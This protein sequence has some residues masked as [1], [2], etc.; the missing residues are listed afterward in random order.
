[1]SIDHQSRWR[2]GVVMA[3]MLALACGGSSPST[4]VDGGSSASTTVCMG[5]ANLAQDLGCAGIQGCV[6]PGAECS[7][8]AKAWVACVQTDLSQCHCESGDDSLNC[9]GAYKPDEGPA[10]CVAQVAAYKAC[11]GMD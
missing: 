11:A 10:K 3:A 8:E 9:E 6:E 2:G 4:P 7:D 5:W 1:M